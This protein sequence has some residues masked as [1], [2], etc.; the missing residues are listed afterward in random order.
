M[1]NHLLFHQDTYLGP[2]SHGWDISHVKFLIR[3][4]FLII[5]GICFSCG[6][7]KVQWLIYAH[8]NYMNP[9]GKQEFNHFLAPKTSVKD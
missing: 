3:N 8:F 7:H 6:F 1:K 4:S 5:K 2:S 9:E